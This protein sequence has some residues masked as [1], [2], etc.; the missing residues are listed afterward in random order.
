MIDAIAD[1]ADV[2]DNN[3]W[4]ELVTRDSSFL[5]LSF[6]DVSTSVRNGTREMR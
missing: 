6:P 5:L 4:Q 1:A 2:E 3:S